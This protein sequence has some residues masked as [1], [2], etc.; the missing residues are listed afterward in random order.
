MFVPL[1]FTMFPRFLGYYELKFCYHLL[2]KTP[3][4][5][6]FSRGVTS[7]MLMFLNKG[8]GAILVSPT[9][10]HG[11]ELSSYANAFF[12]FDWKTFSLILW[13]K[14]LCALICSSMIYPRRLLFQTLLRRKD[15]KAHFETY[16][17][18]VLI[19]VWVFANTLS[20]HVTK[21]I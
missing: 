21:I 17:A 8:T 5:I 9:N 2:Q 16:G 4:D 7:A 6:V 11:I 18:H 12:C 19:S 1:W 3:R 10:Y 20:W 13:V 15:C 14:T